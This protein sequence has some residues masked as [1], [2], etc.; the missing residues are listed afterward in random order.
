MYYKVVINHTSRGVDETDDDF[1]K[2]DTT[3]KDFSTLPLALDFIKK[4]G[5]ASKDVQKERMYVDYK[6]K[7]KTTGWIFTFINSDISHASEKWVQQDWVE[8]FVMESKRID[9][10]K[11]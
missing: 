4:Q 5:Y 10:W 3:D 8:I 9:N 11:I 7:E 1:R 6:G 2:F